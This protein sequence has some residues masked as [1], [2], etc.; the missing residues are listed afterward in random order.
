[1]SCMPS[2]WQ[3]LAS[4][5]GEAFF[6]YKFSECKFTKQIKG[7]NVVY[8]NELSFRPQAKGRPVVF[9][10]PIECVYK[11]PEGWIPPFLNPGSGVSEG[12][13][14]LVFHMALLNGDPYCCSWMNVLLPLHQS[15]ILAAMSTKLCLFESKRGSAVFLPRY[16]SSAIILYIQAF[17][18]GLGDEVYIHCNLVVWD[19]GALGQS[20]KACHVK[21]HG[22]WELLDDP[23]QSS[24]CS[25]CDSVCSSKARRSVDEPHTSSYN[26]VLGPLVIKDQSGLISNATTVGSL[27]GGEYKKKFQH[28][29]K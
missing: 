6:D 21:E 19:D 8:K 12:Q 3:L 28:Q 25:C 22:S 23:S 16:H 26:T 29:L 27:P 24:V 1:G 11:R 17:N 13:S 18:F 10:Q 15:C 14:N 5:D 7:K 9:K 2:K 4:G 20:R